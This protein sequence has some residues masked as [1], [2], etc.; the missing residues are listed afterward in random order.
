MTVKTL[1]GVYSSTYDLTSPVTTLSIAAS[2]YLLAGLTASATGTYTLVNDGQVRG[3]AY[4]VSLAG[5]G[6]VTNIG[7]IVNSATTA[8]SG[9]VILAAGGSLTNAAGALIAGYYGALLEGSASTVINDGEIL[10]GRYGVK[11]V[12]G[13]LVTNGGTADAGALIRGELAVVIALPGTLRNFGTVAAVGTAGLGAALLSGGTIINGSAG[14]RAAA[15]QG[16]SAGLIVTSAAGAVTNYGAVRAT[17]TAGVAIL[18]TEG[19]LVVNGSAADTAAIIAGTVGVQVRTL[20]GT[21]RNFGAIHGG[22]I[23]AGGALG[24]IYLSGGGVVTNGATIDTTAVIDGYV[25]VSAGLIAATV[26]NF[27]RIGDAGSLIGV[28]LQAGGA[29][30]NGAAG[31]TTALIE[32]YVGA[33]G[34]G[35]LTVANFGTIEANGGSAVSTPVHYGLYATAGGRVTNGGTADV[36]ALVQGEIGVGAADD[37]FTVTN[38]GSILGTSQGVYLKAGGAVAN[39]A[40]GDT[41]ALV[42]GAAYGVNFTY[43]SGSSDTLTN[44]GTI[45]A[46]PEGFG[47][48]LRSTG[49][50]TNGSASDAKAV[51]QGEI[52]LELTQKDTAKNW[53]TLQG[54]ASPGSRGAFDGYKCV[55]TNEAGAL[56]SG[57]L[58]AAVG[59][60]ATLTNFGTVQGSQAVVLGASSAR[61]NAEAGSVFT[62]LVIAN[63]GTVDAVGGVSAMSG[64]TTAGKVLGAGTL[65]LDGGASKFILGASL[66]LAGIK[67][68]GGATTVEVATKLAYAKV[69]SQTAGTL[70][71]DTGDKMTFTGTGDSFAGTLT[72][73]GEIAFTGGSD[74]FANLHLSAATMVV[75]GASLT[76][77]GT[78]NLSK[79]LTV[80]SPSVVIAAAGATLTGGG[81]LSLTNHATNL[82]KGASAAATLTNFDRITGAGQLGGGSMTLVNK[83]GGV[84]NGNASSQ[85]TIGTGTATITNAG[86][87]E[88]TGAGGSLIASPVA[89]TGTLTVTAG[90]LSVIDAV[91]GAGVVRIGGGVADFGSTFAQN[92]TFT[93]TSGVLELSHSAS[94]TGKV[95]GFS[96]IGGTALDLLDIASATASASY[97]GTTASGVLTVTDGTHTARIHLIGD[98]TAST[99]TPSSDGHGGTR[100]V[101]PTAAAAGR[102]PPM[103]PLVTAMAGFGGRAG[104][105]LAPAPVPRLA[106]AALAR[107]A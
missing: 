92:V 77:S 30:T 94:Y 16:A 66:T 15:I 55:L 105:G 69:W 34:F 97:S 59:Y 95:T 79:T 65:S 73:A 101:D 6:F 20:A 39:G 3:A 104:F 57:S 51:I 23:A 24:A 53:G 8:G 32:G 44:F 88:N 52:G 37:P 50:V 107:P 43:L 86:I 80:T 54:S 82:I 12:A 38:F 62:G 61:L 91:T 2:G 46:G 74:A 90:V 70:T 1:I 26:T 102:T 10:A 7:T 36:V 42:K 14:D 72:G 5:K 60:Y 85:L 75:S 89:N 58:G 83:A 71:V 41:A 21:I 13:G 31:D 56:I 25:A 63:A 29:I 99:F 27:G 40:A 64:L 93:S 45:L 18:L 28:E 11:L 9:G 78:I 81:T 47:A 17:G 68:A 87:I 103:A 19:G 100:V 84:I 106:V 96:K 4:G 22:A 98:Y 35:A 49:M 76:L 33:V 67:V 48:V